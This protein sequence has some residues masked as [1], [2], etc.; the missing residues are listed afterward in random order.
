MIIVF[1]SGF[2]GLIRLLGRQLQRRLG[3]S[4]RGAARRGGAGRHRRRRVVS[5][6]ARAEEGAVAAVAAVRRRRGSV[7]DDARD[8]V[9]RHLVPLRERPVSVLS[10]VDFTVRRATIHGLIGPNGSGKSTLVDLISGR[11][12][13]VS[14]SIE[15]E[16]VGRSTASGSQTR[17]SHGVAR[18]FQSAVLVNELSATTERPGRPVHARA[19]SRRAVARL[20]RRSRRPAGRPAAA[21]HGSTKSLALRRRRAVGQTSRSPTRPTASQQLDAARRRLRLR[22]RGTV[23]L[24]EPLAGPRPVRGRA[25]R[26]DPH[27]AEA[28][29]REHPPHRAPAAV[30]VRALRRGDR[31]RRRRGRRRAARR[32]RSRP[33]VRVR[34]VYLG[35]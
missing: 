14:G 16:G 9:S 22:A 35:Q 1:P 31:P 8:R 21:A 6:V 30:R 7:P 10:G 32:R 5:A 34:Q 12:R 27:P 3:L 13:P 23:I 28:S 4:G 29:R 11:F 15:I 17:V 26:G 25:R 20:A 2:V 18:T 19:A 33:N 24:D